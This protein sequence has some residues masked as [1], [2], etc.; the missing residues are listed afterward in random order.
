[1]KTRI[2]GPNINENDTAV[3]TGVDYLKFT[4]NSI[5]DICDGMVKKENFGLAI[6]ADIQILV[7]LCEKYSID[8]NLLIKKS[9]IARWEEL[10]NLWLTKN[11]KKLPQEYKDTIKANGV[12]LFNKLNQYGNPF[13]HF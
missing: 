3:N 2:F 7:F 9:Q 4:R 8:A 5:E 12:D 1:M 11:E 10:Y 13:D 6:L